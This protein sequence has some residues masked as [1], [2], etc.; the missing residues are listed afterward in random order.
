MI[1][2]IL[3]L[4]LISLALTMQV[5][6]LGTQEEDV[7]IT[8]ND[9]WI[10]CITDFDT[11]SLPAERAAICAVILREL[12][13]SL[14]TIN[15]RTR[16][17][18]EYAYYEEYAWARERTAAARAL[19]VK[20][21][22]KSQMLFRG[23]PE[24]RYRQNIIKI[25][26]QIE[27]L[28]TS[29]E[30]IE[31]NVPLIN[32]E[33]AFKLH[34]GNIDLVFPVA[35][36]KGTEY[37]FCGDHGADAFL[38]GSISEF[39][40]RYFLSV[41]LYTIFTRSFVWEDSILFSHNDLENALEEITR[42]LL[43]MLSGS[44]PA[45]IAIKA[46]PDETLVLI[47]RSFAG[48]GEIQMLEL[49]PGKITVTASAP[50]HESL[51]FNTEVFQGE[52]INIDI[53]LNPIVYGDMEISGKMEGHV[54]YGALYSGESPL[55]LRLPVDKMEYIEIISSGIDS[56]ESGGLSREIQKGMF[57]FQTSKEPE[58]SQ[59]LSL[60]LSVPIDNNR[61]E[62]ERKR[63]YWAWGTQWVTGITAWIAYYTLTGAGNALRYDIA[64]SNNF[65]EK[66]YNDYSIMNYVSAGAIIA[67]GVA[68]AYGIYR[69][70]R[71]IHFA[72][73]EAA[74]PVRPRKK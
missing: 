16:V 23:E 5:F 15:Y 17:S 3:F 57:V 64:A 35:P 11:A 61:V 41:K 18:P 12:V 22:E 7:I 20:L 71:Y 42:R 43:I 30:N 49:P 56:Q 45:S 32:R 36:G 14:S 69:M 55:M 66:L 50:D 62:R 38:A 1:R 73:K 51:T 28:K 34:A 65:N 58:F 53:K 24:W 26:E 40:G 60:R 10:L 8:Q 44:K 37:K 54:Y 47:N 6:A 39:H 27:Q 19:S 59:T 68:S 2:K 72:D 25:D 4:I 74:L 67:F 70:I 63:Y 31:N 29:L 9:E 33:P 46:E 52:R 13:K 48:R 21:D